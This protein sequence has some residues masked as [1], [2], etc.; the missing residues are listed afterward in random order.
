M[1]T[2]F[3]VLVLRFHAL[4]HHP[5]VGYMLFAVKLS[6]CLVRE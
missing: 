6:S 3:A 2:A 5:Q 4:A 1:L